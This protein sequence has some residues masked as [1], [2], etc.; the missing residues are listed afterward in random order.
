[1]K[2]LIRMSMAVMVIMAI[3]VIQRVTAAEQL[4][5]VL[6]QEK[7]VELST[8]LAPGRLDIREVLL[9]NPSA[10]ETVVRTLLA[11]WMD[12]QPRKFSLKAGE[13]KK[14]LLFVWVPNNEES[15][16]EGWVTFRAANGLQAKMKVV[17]SEPEKAPLLLDPNDVRIKELEE[18]LS[19][20]NGKV[21]KLEA[22]LAELEAAKG[23]LATKLAN[24]IDLLKGNLDSKLKEYIS[25]AEEK[26]QLE[27]L[28]S[29]LQ[30]EVV[31]LQKEN[32]QQK[33]RVAALEKELAGWKEEFG[34]VRANINRLRTLHQALCEGLKAEIERGEVLVSF[35]RSID[36]VILPDLFPS[37][38]T[39][40]SAAKADL[41]TK[42]GTILKTGLQPDFR[43]EVRGHADA[44]PVTG[45]L[46]GK[47]SDN[48][49]LSA[50]RALRILYILSARKGV[51]IDGKYLS[52]SGCGAEQPVADNA[53]SEGRAKNRRVEI[54]VSIPE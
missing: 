13:R 53:T 47:Y 5:V 52:F 20:K 18:E 2:G 54:I 38:S 12:I 44:S 16:R 3:M 43:I 26:K 17:I 22:Q 10:S 19:T 39:Y 50:G 42:V 35:R 28:V 7:A 49:E 34:A 25:C 21:A 41:I 1:M 11:E 36:L 51:E 6:G 33:E 29:K 24:E 32:S 48:W 9:V 45:R 31:L 8:A 46:A 23:V 30:A 37:G 4:E 15:A 40:P 27:D 14:C